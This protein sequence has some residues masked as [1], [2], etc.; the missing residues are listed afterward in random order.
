VKR[1]EVRR[2]GKER[3]VDKKRRERNE[4]KRKVEK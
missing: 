2:G 4:K 3:K 1:R